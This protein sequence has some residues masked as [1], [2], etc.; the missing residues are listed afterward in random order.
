[1]GGIAVTLAYAV[2]GTAIRPDLWADPLGAMLKIGP[3]LV[4]MLAALAIL[5]E[6]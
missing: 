6:R 3:I 1:L 2:A 5:D 4:L